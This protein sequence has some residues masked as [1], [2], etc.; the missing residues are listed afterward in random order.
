MSKQY[1][2]GFKKNAVRIHSHCGYLSPSEYENRYYSE[3]VKNAC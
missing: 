2:K 3:N 1:D